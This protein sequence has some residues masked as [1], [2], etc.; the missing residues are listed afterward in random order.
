MADPFDDPDFAT[1][2][3]DP[4]RRRREVVRNKI[5]NPNAP[6]WAR[7]L[8]KQQAAVL[9]LD[10]AV[11]ILAEQLKN[12]NLRWSDEE[13]AQ[14]SLMQV[15]EY[16]AFE[17]S[18]KR[19]TQRR[20]DYEDDLLRYSQRVEAYTAALDGLRAVSRLQITSD[21]RATQYSQAIEA[22][23]AIDVPVPFAQ[24][25]VLVD[26]YDQARRW[27]AEGYTTPLIQSAVQTLDPVRVATV[28]PDRADVDKALRDTHTSY[29]VTKLRQARERIDVAIKETAAAKKK[30]Q[31]QSSNVRKQRKAATLADAL[32]VLLGSDRGAWHISKI[33][34][35]ELDTSV[36]DRVSESA[37]QLQRDT[38]T[39]AQVQGLLNSPAY[40]LD[41]LILTQLTQETR[42]LQ[43]IIAGFSHDDLEQV[44]LVVRTIKDSA[45]DLNRSI[46][47]IREYRVR[48]DPVLTV[49]EQEMCTNYLGAWLDTAESM[50]TFWAGLLEAVQDFQT[51][52][53]NESAVI[54]FTRDRFLDHVHQR[55]WPD[56]TLR[57]LG[58]SVNVILHDP[59]NKASD[60]IQSINRML[61]DAVTAQSRI[62]AFRRDLQPIRELAQDIP[63]QYAVIQIALRR[64]NSIYQS[65]YKRSVT[66]TISNAANTAANSI[67]VSVGNAAKAVVQTV[68]FRTGSPQPDV[69]LGAVSSSSDDE[70]V[71]FSSSSDTLFFDA[72]EPL[73]PVVP[74]PV[75]TPQ[76]SI[77]M[78]WARL[79]LHARRM[80]NDPEPLDHRR[81]TLMRW[82][83]LRL[84]ARQ[85]QP[86]AAPLDHR[87]S[88][89]MRWARSRLRPLTIVAP[90]EAR[91]ED[92]E[93][94]DF[95]VKSQRRGPRR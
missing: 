81:S 6:E 90:Q 16:N 50:R 48:N 52:I 41:P 87:R 10:V 54:G 71:E 3:T 11:D 66:V 69:E 39:D 32:L 89:L 67:A 34:L 25:R 79:R 64:I 45:E 26:L 47:R 84:H 82:A 59:R 43:T 83:R 65:A 22:M 75:V 46:R 18:Y 49:K 92:S 15:P 56:M 60:D 28:P 36:F 77:L 61:S 63:A 78:R 20:L 94:T 86:I 42:T 70:F 17:E 12:L 73:A 51:F 35:R 1:L 68:R 31:R 88:I 40:S 9:R 29:I 27:Q 91:L 24:E 8:H 80:Q 4:L 57:R 62:A 74:P 53:E 33:K 58:S 19:E 23:E 44:I 14:Y 55:L 2:V 21:A 5:E 7:A 72:V 37:Q 13:K 93:E 85:I 95:P 30:I 38:P 76:T